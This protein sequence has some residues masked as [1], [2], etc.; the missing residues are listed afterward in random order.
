MHIIKD[1]LFPISPLFKM[2]REESNTDLKEMY[3][4]FNMGHRMEI[5]CIKAN[6]QA[7]INTSAS[8]NIEAKIIGRCERHT[9]RKLSIVTS[10][11]TFEY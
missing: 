11:S 5:Y 2:I 4:V 10:E 6:A 9:G 3:K 1:D 8:F 7:I